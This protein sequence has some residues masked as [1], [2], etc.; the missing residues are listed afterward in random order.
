[1]ALSINNNTLDEMI[2]VWRNICIVLI[3]PNPKQSIQNGSFIIIENNPP[4]LAVVKYL[5]CP[6]CKKGMPEI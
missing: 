5:E 1:M 6:S 3:S 2:I 4:N